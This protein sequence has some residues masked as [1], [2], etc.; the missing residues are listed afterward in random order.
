MDLK[1]AWSNEIELIPI[2]EAPDVFYSN[3]TYKNQ[4]LLMPGVLEAIKS[5]IEQELRK[6]RKHKTREAK[7]NDFPF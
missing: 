7:I 6:I 3:E 5:A 1:E 2:V 4:F